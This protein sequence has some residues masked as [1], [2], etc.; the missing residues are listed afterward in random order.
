MNPIVP[1]I[2]WHVKVEGTPSGAVTSGKTIQPTL[3]QIMITTA[4]MTNLSLAH[5]V[6]ISA[7]T[8]V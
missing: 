6:G 5:D 3:T 7:I 8:H 2:Q 4:A 1:P